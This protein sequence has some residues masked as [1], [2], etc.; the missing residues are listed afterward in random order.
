[1]VERER[2]LR[3]EADATTDE[4]QRA[5]LT[6]DADALRQRADRLVD[7]AKEDTMTQ[8]AKQIR[9]AMRKRLR[10][11][12]MQLANVQEKDDVQYPVE[13]QRERQQQR[14]LLIREWTTIEGQFY[15]EMQQWVAD[16][17]R[18]AERL[19][20]SDP[21]GDAAQES[22]RVSENLEIARLAEPHI[23]AGRTQVT[24]HL[25]NEARRFLSLDLPDR[26]RLY[27]EAARR[28]GV[29]DPSLSAALEDAYDR[30][31]PHRRQARAIEQSAREQQDLFDNDRYSLRLVHKVGNQVQASTAS[32]LLAAR[33]GESTPAGMLDAAHGESQ[34]V[35]AETGQE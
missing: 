30:T 1:L 10:D 20:Y 5:R 23:G 16:Q 15:G 4:A 35:G 28:A 12:A 14:A 6:A 17:A 2:E 9:A 21:L 34:L 26:A 31:V 25:L 7:E 3:A 18:E 24:N 13:F 32:K 11:L 33:R 22:R 19:R 27:V 8:S 29:D